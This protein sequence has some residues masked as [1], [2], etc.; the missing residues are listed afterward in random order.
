MQQT[1]PTSPHP[2]QG[3]QQSPH[4]KGNT[5]QDQIHEGDQGQNRG[6]EESLVFTLPSQNETQSQENQGDQENGHD[7]A[8]PPSSQLVK[9]GTNLPPTKSHAEL[10]VERIISLPPIPFPSPNRNLNTNSNQVQVP[11]QQRYQQ[12]Q[13]GQQ[14]DQGR[15]QLSSP[16]DRQYPNQ[17]V[18]APTQSIPISHPSQTSRR[19]PFAN[20]PPSPSGIQVN[21]SPLQTPNRPS[22]P[23]SRFT[24]DPVATSRLKQAT[25][26]EGTTYALP[27]PQG[28]NRLVKSRSRGLS[29]AF[30]VPFLAG[31]PGQKTLEKE[32]KENGSKS[33]V[34]GG[35]G[36]EAQ[37][38]VG[39][40]QERGTGQAAKTPHRNTTSV[41]EQVR[42]ALMAQ[43]SAAT[44][45]RAQAVQVS[46]KAPSHW[47]EELT[48]KAG[49]A[50]ASIFQ[51]DQRDR[52]PGPVD[53]H[54]DT[55]SQTTKPPSKPNQPRT[56]PFQ[57]EQDQ[58]PRDN[59]Q[60]SGIGPTESSDEVRQASGQALIPA[61]PRSQLQVQRS[62]RPTQTTQYQDK[63]VS[64][65][66]PLATQQQGKKTQ[67][68]RMSPMS[69]QAPI[70]Q[71]A[72][73]PQDNRRG[74]HGQQDRDPAQAQLQPQSRAR[75]RNQA[76]EQYM[77]DD[78]YDKQP[79]RARPPQGSSPTPYHQK[80]ITEY[81]G[82]RQDTTNQYT[83]SDRHLDE[84][85]EQPSSEVNSHD[86]A[87]QGGNT[88]NINQSRD[89]KRSRDQ[90]RDHDDVH[91]QGEDVFH[92]QP[93]KQKRQK[94]GLF[95]ASSETEV[96]QTGE[97]DDDVP[98]FD[99]FAEVS[100]F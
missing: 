11:H 1:Y 38:G 24:T 98:Q 43:K 71:T 51:G 90:A 94:N 53:P 77:N 86:Y 48:S 32:E 36:G 70:R 49:L 41:G 4:D 15:Y 62:G 40:G 25:T 93:G 60:S 17:Q 99:A 89:S 12:A 7:D 75:S 39:E 100:F 5:H 21:S 29:Q 61:R 78:E 33:K 83:S 56:A 44:E 91:D 67:L 59:Q 8:P 35:V 85:D 95:P 54:L 58:R 31:S 14:G 82:Q 79:A 63:R 34:D 81:T 13:E 74:D 68:K 2:A 23:S 16:P 76:Q 9:Y 66:Q 84:Y 26:A 96:E 69:D 27:P 73:A 10:M 42:Q 18:Q 28:G 45:K 47:K 72:P 3:E 64:R 50:Q 20:P 22:D 55:R 30:K 65:D 97:G 57:P 37:R 88:N 87:Y 6:E 80:D 52:R 46:Y 19:N 92:V